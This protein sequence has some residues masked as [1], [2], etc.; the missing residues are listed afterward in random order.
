LSLARPHDRIQQRL[1]VQQDLQHHSHYLVFG[2]RDIMFRKLALLPSSDTRKKFTLCSLDSAISQHIPII[3]TVQ[4]Q[5]KWV[6][7]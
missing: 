3:F 7:T 6:A 5:H 1:V 4:R 2:Y